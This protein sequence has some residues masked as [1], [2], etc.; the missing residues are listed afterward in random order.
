MCF[1]QIRLRQRALRDPREADVDRVRTPRI[2][3]VLEAPSRWPLPEVAGG[4]IECLD[5]KGTRCRTAVR[6]RYK[7][8]P[9][10]A[11]TGLS[12]PRFAARGRLF[13]TLSCATM[14]PGNRLLSESKSRR[15]ARAPSAGTRARQHPHL[16]KPLQHLKVVQDCRDR[17]ALRFSWPV[18][19][20][21]KHDQAAR[22][23][24]ASAQRRRGLESPPGPRSPGEIEHAHRK[25]WPV[26]G[27]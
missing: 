19:R 21:W 24:E 10:A 2:I 20:C 4:V 8:M 7:E 5:R 25:R 23:G 22:I 6:A 26:N 13:P 15:I 17:A 14:I 11:C 16:P 18:S 12:K 27:D 3:A 1:E 9:V